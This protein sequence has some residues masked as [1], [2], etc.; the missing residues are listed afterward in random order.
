[1]R[2]INSIQ[3]N[4][5]MSTVYRL[6]AEIDRWP[7]VLPHYRWVTTLKRDGNTSIVEMAAR[8]GIIPVKWVSIQ[9]RL[10]DEGRIL[11]KHIGGPT[12]GMWVEWALT[13]VDGGIHVTIIHDLQLER[14]IV[15][16]RLGEWIVG[17]IFVKNIADK[18]LQHIKAVAEGKA[19]GF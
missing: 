2:T 14:K 8:R 7:E 16:S 15:G 17:E 10:E 9:R 11:Y 4:A 5:P 19:D 18:T 12:K 13:P 6:A 3:I 1:M